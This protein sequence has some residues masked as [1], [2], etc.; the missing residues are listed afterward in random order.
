MQDERAPGALGYAGFWPV[1]LAAHRRRATRLWHFAGTAA[2][3]L[4]LLAAALSWDWWPLAAAP[5]AG[6][7]P[8]WISHFMIEGN[9]PATFGHPL[10]SFASDFRMLGLW[11]AGRLDGELARH[12]IAD[13]GQAPVRRA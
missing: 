11:L 3:L 13:A 8:A 10:W 2:G 9:R 1:Y 6:Y 4:C 12:G 7:L 5:F